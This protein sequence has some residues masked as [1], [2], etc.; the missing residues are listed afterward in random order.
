MNSVKQ[1]LK[2]VSTETI[3]TAKALRKLY[4]TRAAFSIIWITLVLTLSK[5]NP[6]IA[7]VLFIIYPAWDAIAT[8]FDI[9]ANPPI[10]NKTPQYVNFVISSLTTIV[11]I[12][13]L[14]K[15]IPEALMVFG[16]WALL[17]GLIQFII[18]LR[19]RKEFGGQWPM[20]ISGAQSILAG[21][22]IFATA[23]K[24]NQGVDSLAG[25]SAFGAFYF[26]L[27]AIRLGKTIKSTPAI[28]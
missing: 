27:G 7:A 4:I 17:A 23:H 19:R 13:A 10:T 12:A 28:A 6:T 22:F 5:T 9:N 1:A 2:A 24:P 3:E 21:V 11:V 20:I 15:G 26:I 14:Q 18:G 25:Y 8:I 16:I